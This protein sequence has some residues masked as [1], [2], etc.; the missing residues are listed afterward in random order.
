MALT[1]IVVGIHDTEPSLVGIKAVNGFFGC[2]LGAIKRIGDVQVFNC[3][4]RRS[5]LLKR[6]QMVNLLPRKVLFIFPFRASRVN[7]VKEGACP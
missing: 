5:P 7:F 4:C 3:F 6:P 1:K 2:P